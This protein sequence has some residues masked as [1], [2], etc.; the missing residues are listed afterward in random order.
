MRPA[1]DSAGKASGIGSLIAERI[2]G[3]EQGGFV[4]RI[5]PEEDPDQSRKAE[6]EDDGERGYDGGPAR[7]QGQK[8]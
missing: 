7:E 1:D 2:D 6:C 4:G 5:E 8:L 3:V